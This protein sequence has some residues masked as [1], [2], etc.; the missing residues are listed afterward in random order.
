MVNTER[1]K[2]AFSFSAAHINT[3]LIPVP[4]VQ[5]KTGLQTTLLWITAVLTG[6]TLSITTF[7]LFVVSF[8]AFTVLFSSWTILF[9]ELN[10]P[11]WLK[12]KHNYSNNEFIPA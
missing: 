5:F 10:Q 1:G 3:T 12:L 2:T 7:L 8:L 6:F 9:H 11:F 4:F